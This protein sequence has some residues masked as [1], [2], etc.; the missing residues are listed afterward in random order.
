MSLKEYV[1]KRKF[2]ETPEPKPSEIEPK[3]KTEGRFFI[4]RHDAT[5]LHYDFRLEIGGTLKSW[6]VPKGPPMNFSHKSLA[7]MVEDHPIDYGGFEGNIP[8]GNYGAGSVMLWDKGT[9]ELIGEESAEEQI[10]RG[11]L[12]FVLHGNKINGTFALVRMKGRGKG[13]E[14]LLIKKND[15]F[16]DPD[17]DVEAHAASVKTGRTQEEIANDLP[18]HKRATKKSAPS[19]KPSKKAPPAKPRKHSELEGLQGAVLA[20]MPEHVEP[21]MAFAVSKPPAGKNWLYEVKWDGVRAICF[22]R[23]GMLR[24]ISRNGNSFDRQYPELSVLPHY[25]DAETAILDGE[26]A[27]LDEQGRSRFELIQPRIHQTDPNS[28]AHL[29]RSTP[30]KL[31][32]FD[33]LYLDGYDLRNVPLIERKRV[34]ESILKPFERMQ[35]SAHFAAK[36]EQMLEAARQHG[37]E[38]VL[39]KQEDSKYES[40]RSNAWLKIKVVGQQE[41]V[42]CGYT[43]GGERDTFSSLVLGVYDKGKL[44]Y[45]GNVGTGFNDKSLRYLYERMKPLETAR[46]PFDKK[47]P[48]QRPT[49]WLKPELVCEIKFSNW[50]RDNRLRAPV[51]LGLRDDKRPEECVREPAPATSNSEPALEAEEPSSKPIRPKKSAKPIVGGVVEIPPSAKELVVTVDGKPLKF[52]N[53]N[54]VLY[55]K[56]GY[57]KRDLLLYYDAVADLLV[58]Y[59]KDRPLSLK[60]YPNG[61]HEE[62]FFQKDIKEG[63][64]WLRIE[65]IHSEHRGAPIRFAVVDD[66]AGLLYLTNLG[67]LDQNPW[68]SRMQTLECPDYVLI[69]LDPQDCGY[70]KIV[71]AANLVRAKLELVG[72]EGYPKTTGGDGMHVYIPVEPRY[73][74]EQVRTFAEILST[75]V[76]S[77][78]PDLF[79]TP[80]SVA[81][82]TRGKVYFDYLQISTGKTISAPYS[83]RAYDGALVSTPLVW[84][85]VEK[86]L[87]PGQFTIKNV[88]ER[89]EKVGDLF[90]PVLDKPQRLEGA[91]KRLSQLVA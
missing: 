16:T 76:I 31:F 69:D 75:I 29:A 72:L 11:D 10:K 80:R 59:L 62:F 28:V 24:M 22:I 61:I 19:A 21:M 38:G 37:L 67:C 39:A 83:V 82:R 20:P 54:K 1:S 13:N 60:R 27:V 64:E 71:E 81:K 78:K 46:S 41:F 47:E 5:R 87:R 8:A 74:Y 33:L 43:H 63:P 66:R 52:T 50:T 56:D 26:I 53:L 30:A 17:W 2:G 6:A 9:F 89:F 34:L 15:E 45:A 32:V 79:T 42:I 7:M 49:T 23:D 86:G 51:Y 84:D 57:T 44:V 3:K 18:A 4:Q 40:R 12:K 14:W 85:E 70:D 73:S 36:G 90:R 35:Y 55:P 48:M 68:M 77:E 88:L 65:P 58:P 91:L 25:V